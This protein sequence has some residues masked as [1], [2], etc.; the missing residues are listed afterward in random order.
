MKALIRH[1]AFLLPLCLLASLA[2]ACLSDPVAPASEPALP[3]VS[4]KGESITRLSLTVTGSFADK[5]ST[6]KE[7]GLQMAAGSVADWQVIVQN[8]PRDAEGRFTHTVEGLTPG[9]VYFFRTYISNGLTT[10]YS[11]TTDAVKTLEKSEAVLSPVTLNGYTL[12]AGIE[13]DG[14]RTIQSV[15][16]LGGASPEI[17]DLIQ[18]GRDLPAV[19]SSDGR[20]FSTTVSSEFD[21]GETYYFVAYAENSEDALH[22]FKGYSSAAL[23]VTI[24]EEFPTRIEDPAFA[25]YLTTHFDSNGDGLLS[26]AEL[27]AITAIEVNTDAVVSVD[28]I[29]QMP[30][31]RRLSCCGSARGAGK[32]TSLDVSH[33]PKL[34]TLRCDN[35]KL[36][37]LTVGANPLLDTLSCAGNNLTSLGVSGNPDLVYLN[38]AQ[39]QLT[40][41]DVE[42]NL[43]LRELNIGGNPISVIDIYPCEDLQTF[44]ARG[45]T[46]LSRIL[47]W[48]DFD[49]SAHPDFTKESA[50]AYACS[51]S[52][53][54]PLADANFKAYCVANFDL[55]HNGRLS[56]GE[57]EEVREIT[58]STDE[59]ASLEGLSYFT[60]LQKLSCCGSQQRS[61]FGRWSGQLADLDLSA[62]TALTELSCSGNQLQALDLSHNPDLKKLDCSGNRLSVLDVSNNPRLTSLRCGDNDLATLPLAH[63]PQL[64]D[65]SCEANR[66]IALDVALLTAL[67]ALDCSQN[68]IVSLDISGNK[69]LSSLNCTDNPMT[70]VILYAD[71]LVTTL[72]KPESTELFYRIDGL[73]LSVDNL[74]LQV[75]ES[76]VLSAV[77]DPETAVD[78]DTILA[79]MVWRSSDEKIATVSQTGAVTAIAVGTCTVSVSYDD[80]SASCTVRVSPVPVASITLTP[81]SSE[82][83]IDE[84]VQLQATILP[85]NASAQTIEWKSSR[86]AVATVSDSG[87][88][89]GISVG[90]CTITATADGKEATCRITVLP[91][92][93]TDIEVDPTSRELYI[94]EDFTIEATVLPANATD[95]DVQWRS[96]DEAVATVTSYGLV[97]AEGEGSCT[98]TAYIGDVEASCEVTVLAIPVSR[99]SLNRTEWDM[100]VGDSFTLQ[101]S[102]LPTNATHRTVIWSTSDRSVATVSSSGTVTAVAVG[103]CTITAEADGVRASCRVTVQ[104]RAIEVT[105]VTLSPSSLSLTEG[106]TETLTAII[107]PANAT[108]KAVTW[109]SDDT[110]VATVSQEGA[111]T[112]VG[113]G[114]CNILA[115]AGGKSAACRVTVAASTIPVTS[116]TLSQTEWTTPVGGSLTLTATVL[117]DNATDKT[118]TWTSSDESIAMVSTTGT[119]IALAPGTCTI[120]AS[121]GGRSAGCSVSVIVPVE[122]ITLSE[123][124]CNL[125]INGTKTL[126]ATVLPDNAT[127]KTIV[128]SSDNESIATVSSDGVVTGH[129]LGSCIITASAGGQM[130]TCQILVGAVPIT[131]EF[132]PDP[133]FRA[134]IKKSDFDKNRDGVL[135]NEEI[136]LI[137]H[138][139]LW[140]T[141]GVSYVETLAG[142][143]YFSAL[144]YLYCANAQ[145]TS[146]DLS[147]NLA[148]TELYCQSNKLTT[149]NVSN[150]VSLI[151]LECGGNNLSELD[152]TNLTSLKSL[153]CQGNQ[154]TNLNLK[155][156][157]SLNRLECD[158][159]KIAILDLSNKTDL[160]TVYCGY[161]EL[162]SLNVT[163]CSSL[164]SLLCWE[165]KLVSL[166]VSDC[167]SLSFLQCRNN[168]YLTEIWLK[169]GQTI[170][171]FS[172]DTAVATIKYKD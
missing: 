62:N 162:S 126:V 66:L 61:A 3:T 161:N 95:Q 157:T 63:N 168:P 17:R 53:A 116:I 171:S 56:V 151:N 8:P 45:C 75:E 67:T 138:I 34:T 20:S 38:C 35:N 119:I 90:S 97:E 60:G 132:F 125:A 58:V 94:G 159:N 23:P 127:D 81:S 19:L 64:T 142:I 50:T 52:A 122:S 36:T 172:Y 13:D 16:F 86:P 4:V 135:S 160:T 83:L 156:N 93:V 143:E 14:G 150:N 73:S 121:A 47:T 165:N 92:P 43:A 141:S 133:E 65:L 99:V 25:A 102:V 115:T 27:R 32:L 153:H 85:E 22:T 12:S 124:V 51:P 107:L 9:G 120:T 167:L 84:T 137:T 145:L 170:D 7:Y 146:L 44:N 110:S 70:Q 6:V 30:E 111:V 59:I 29:S 21:L 118:V 108:D 89:T 88:V 77:I 155:H 131:S 68:Q 40:Q 2:T 46:A 42:A 129:T 105:S 117:P 55:D 10:K 114:T 106:E 164:E 48:A 158:N 31:L 69:R 1:F 163:G 49:E 91:V 144:T 71:Q 76:A 5:G 78:P 41:L 147:Q 166:D 139:N 100:V 28:E 103:S 37:A 113:V 74:A 140:T 24:T 11:A 134:Y 98:I 148:L 57:A 152:V 18:S 39:N 128:W 72:Q 130:A 109:S 54:V 101:A 33:N 104:A 79:R 96:S 80:K 82:I 26:W 112:A 15:G 169:T 136:E 154:L 149:L 123:T 87:L